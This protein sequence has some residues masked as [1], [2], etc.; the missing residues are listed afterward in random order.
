MILCLF[1]ILKIASFDIIIREI[2][3]KLS[4]D[5]GACVMKSFT[6]PTLALFRTNGIFHKLHTIKAGWF[7][8]CI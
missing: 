3:D 5:H 8:H 2:D 1:N 7:D 4:P 6:V